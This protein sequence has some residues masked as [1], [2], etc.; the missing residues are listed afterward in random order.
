MSKK[1]MHIM[2]DDNSISNED[3]DKIYESLSKLNDSYDI[4][5]T[6][7]NVQIS[8]YNQ[9]IINDIN[10]KIDVLLSDM[11]R[12][13]KF[14]TAINNQIKHVFGLQNKQ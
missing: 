10:E 2:I 6:T 5:I 12:F 3:V 7:N 1:F 4:A 13:N 8:T 11:D 14:T 9:D